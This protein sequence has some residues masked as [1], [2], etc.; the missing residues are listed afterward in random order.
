[1]M[2]E[3]GCKQNWGAVAP[4]HHVSTRTSSTY[5]RLETIV[6]EGCE[7]ESV[8]TKKIFLYLPVVLPT[9]FYFLLYKDVT[10]CA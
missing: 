6:E 8:F 3:M 9:V 10:R 1:M 2:K 5:P 7:N 4:A